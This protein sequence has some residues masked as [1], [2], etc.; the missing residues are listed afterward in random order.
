MQ[1]DAWSWHTTARA[2]DCHTDNGGSIHPIFADQSDET[3]HRFHALAHVLVSTKTE[4]PIVFTCHTGDICLKQNFT[5]TIML[6]IRGIPF[7]P[8][9]LPRDEPLTRYSPNSCFQPPPKFVA[10]ELTNEKKFMP[11]K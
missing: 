2:R 5:M 7:R 3:V 8:A 9:R 10:P 6:L 1:C 4:H 11:S